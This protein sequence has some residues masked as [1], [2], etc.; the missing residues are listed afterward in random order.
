MAPALEPDRRLP[1]GMDSLTHST[2]RQPDQLIAS[3]VR[4][5]PD[6]HATPSDAVGADGVAVGLNQ[7]DGGPWRTR[8][9]AGAPE[10]K[11]RPQLASSAAQCRGAAV[12][13]IRPEPEGK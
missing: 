12:R 3:E 4:E 7:L 13:V 2:A 5:D 1:E 6:G 8:R 11:V 9:S 10:A